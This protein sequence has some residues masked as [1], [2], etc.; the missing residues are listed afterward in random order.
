MLR[1]IH[2]VRCLLRIADNPMTDTA[3][4]AVMLSPVGGFTA[5]DLAR[6]MLCSKEGCLYRHCLHRNI[7]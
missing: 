7:R 2:L 3:M 5:E 1:L 6:L 4:G